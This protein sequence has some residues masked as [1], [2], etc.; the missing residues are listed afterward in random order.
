MLKDADKEGLIRVHIPPIGGDLG[1]EGL[2]DP[3]IQLAVN[4]RQTNTGQ[5]WLNP[6]DG[7]SG[8]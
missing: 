1:M 5:V 7:H 4:A 6:G 3:D 8:T 2:W